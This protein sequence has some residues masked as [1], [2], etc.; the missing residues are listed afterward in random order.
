MRLSVEYRVEIHSWV[1]T[2]TDGVFAIA[3]AGE[4]L[5]PLQYQEMVE[6]VNRAHAEGSDSP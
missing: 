4:Y 1:W 5:S 3:W 2:L 6:A